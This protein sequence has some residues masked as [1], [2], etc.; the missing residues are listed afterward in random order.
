L[1]TK[2]HLSLDGHQRPQDID[3]QISLNVAALFNTDV[4]KSVLQYLRSITIESVHG[5]A[6]TDTELRHMEGQ[7]YIVGIIEARIRHAH[8]VKEN[9]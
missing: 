9:E 4:G 2:A 3:K 5:A 8:K 1:A 6:V 7:R